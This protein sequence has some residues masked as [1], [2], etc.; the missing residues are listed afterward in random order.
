M[1]VLLEL[2]LHTVFLHKTNLTGEYVSTNNTKSSGKV[3]LD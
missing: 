3:Q 2:L 1:F